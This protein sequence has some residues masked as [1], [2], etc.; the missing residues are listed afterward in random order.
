M[1]KRILLLTDFSKNALNAIKYALSLY[2]ESECTFYLL[3]TNYV[4][5]Y[6]IDNPTFSLSGQRTYNIKVP[7]TE[8]RYEELMQELKLY[9]K[10]P[11]HSFH[12]LAANNALIESVKDAIATYDIDIIVMGTKGLTSSRTVVFGRNTITIMEK[13]TEC[14]VLAVPEDVEFT[15]PKEIV[16][17]TDFKNPFKRREL[18][19]MINI[20]Q[21]H[22]ADIRV[23]HVKE[24][25]ELNKL[26]QGNKE[27]LDTLLKGVGHSFHELEEMTVRA[28][29]NAFVDSRG[30]DIVAFVNQKHNFFT[31]IV[32]KPLVAELGNHSRVPVLVLRYRIK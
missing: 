23:L 24:S 8:D 11:K 31:K 18:N 17:P 27:L 4:D 1:E 12:T 30:S 15:P 5:G 2:T 9:R 26:Q 16:F 14:P 10:N 20:A 22:N 7:K 6:P 3:Y 32:S 28:G 13:V 29:I 19:Y 21:M 25:A